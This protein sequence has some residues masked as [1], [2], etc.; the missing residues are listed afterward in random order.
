MKK[1]F[2]RFASMTLA[3]AMAA[4]VITAP[5]D[6]NAA[7][8]AT[9]A[10]KSVTVKV[11]KKVTIKLKNKNKKAKYTFTTSKKKVAT[12]SKS[13]VIKGIA[14][15]SAKI[16]VRETLNKKKRILGKVTVKVKRSTAPAAPDVPVV[17]DTPAPA[18]ATEAPTATPVYTK[19]PTPTPRATKEPVN[20]LKDAVDFQ[21]GTVISYD[22]KNSFQDENFQKICK[23]NFNLI[24]FENEMKGYSLL[25]LEAC[26]TSEDGM[27]GC[28]F[29]KADEMVKWCADNGLKVRG[30]VLIW[31]ASMKD[32]FFY[33]NYDS[34]SEDKKLVDAETLKKRMQ[35]YCKTVVTHFEEKFPGTVVC[36]DVVNEAIDPNAQKDATTGLCLNRNGNFFKILGGEYIKYAFKY[37]KEAVAEAKK[38]NP[39]SNILLYYNDY[40]TFQKPKDDR[41]VELIKYLNSDPA[42]PLL[43]CMGM[44][45]YVQYNW[46]DPKEITAALNKYAKQGVKIGVN[47]LTVRM[48][49][50]IAGHKIGA[51]DISDHEKKYA[52][53][54]KAYVNFSQSHP[55]VLTNVSIW[56]L[57]DHVNLVE[58]DEEGNKDYDYDIYGTHSGLFTDEYAPKNVFKVV[59]DQLNK[60]RYVD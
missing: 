55:G 58:F 48:N 4:S 52:A 54:M 50:K 24:S 11:G 23:E 19:A 33:E 17:T 39:D 56:G 14:A 44:E 57:T 51:K 31:E 1:N 40:N 35:S 59:L 16:T 42:N 60:L 3:F 45:G 53:L 32:Y 13:G 28:N 36:W 10:K 37:A 9:L 6:A 7:K 18:P 27:P 12:V 22:G 34:E 26:Q 46:P 29:E 25:D 5:A 38:I 8:K 30:H 43:D 47:E 20:N 21:M 15:G 41:I 2:K 49:E